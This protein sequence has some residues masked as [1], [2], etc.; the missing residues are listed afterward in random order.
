MKGRIGFKPLLPVEKAK[1]EIGRIGFMPL[2]QSVKA[3]FGII[4]KTF[5]FSLI[6]PILGGKKRIY[7]DFFD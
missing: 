3:K 5:F 1:Y 6:R 2:S 7:L 4:F